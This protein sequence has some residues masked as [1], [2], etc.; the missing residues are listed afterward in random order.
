MSDTGIYYVRVRGGRG[1][2]GEGAELEVGPDR[3]LCTSGGTTHFAI[4]RSK[5]L[6]AEQTRPDT[7]LL[8][9]FDNDDDLLVQVSITSKNCLA[10]MDE[11]TRT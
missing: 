5:L 7:I 2:T 10:I 11:I 3:L 6:L 4:P 9:F 1:R 8:N